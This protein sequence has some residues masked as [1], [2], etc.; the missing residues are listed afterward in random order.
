MTA[1]VFPLTMLGQGHR[2]EIV[3]NE[4]YGRGLLRHLED[5]GLN[6]GTVI[7]VVTAGNPGP[8]LLATEDQQIALGQRIA[9]QIMVKNKN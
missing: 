4:S 7:E 2:A 1:N 5:L 8:F 6:S 3:A 9:A